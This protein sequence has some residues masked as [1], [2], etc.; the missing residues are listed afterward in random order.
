MPCNSTKQFWVGDFTQLFCDFN[1]FPQSTNLVDNMNA[2]TRLVIVIALTVLY[3]SLRIALMVLIIGLSLVAI[4]YYS[5]EKVDSKTPNE[6]FKGGLHFEGRQPPP[7][8]CND[9]TPITPNDPG[10]LSKNQIL[11]QGGSRLHQANPKTYVKPLIAPPSHD[12]SSWK[13]NDFVHHSG[14]NR[15][16]NFDLARAGYSLDSY[17][18][19]NKTSF[20][21]A[22]VKAKVL[23]APHEAETPSP[24]EYKDRL[25]TQTIQPGVYQKDL[26]CEPTNSLIGIT[27]PPQLHSN[28]VQKLP[29]GGLK[30]TELPYIGEINLRPSL[31]TPVDK[32]SLVPL[33]EDH[34][35]GS[36]PGSRP[37]SQLDHHPGS[38]PGSQLQPPF[39]VD[40]SPFNKPP[41]TFPDLTQSYDNV[42]DPRLTGY[43][44]QSR[45]YIDPMTGSPSWYYKDVESITKPNYITRS[46]IDTLPFAD[47]YGPDKPNP[48]AESTGFREMVN[49]HFHDSQIAFRTDLQTRLMR[50]RNS[51][52]AQRRAAPISTQA[53]YMAGARAYI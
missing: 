26:T 23:T 22:P 34:H 49:Q 50:K 44:D 20:S 7:R 8:F 11:T 45:F 13:A 31:G 32:L 52:V 2:L 9:A 14:T 37:G 33:Q 35:P 46:K 16:G 18:P 12:L 43:G 6:P 51:E 40:Q 28:E 21:P 39:N 15:K 4:L 25:L 10:Y 42:Y 27:A 47:T 41:G 5:L 19:L 17:G 24:Q 36:H 1:I 38:H 30:L 3:F 53:R 48:Y 29:N